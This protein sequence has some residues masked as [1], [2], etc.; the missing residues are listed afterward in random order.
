[1]PL[2]SP[3][4]LLPLILSLILSACAGVR[5]GEGRP[6]ESRLPVSAE[7]GLTATMVSWLRKKRPKLSGWPLQRCMKRRRENQRRP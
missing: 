2:C 1:M 3:R 5:G 7:G 4:K 6:D